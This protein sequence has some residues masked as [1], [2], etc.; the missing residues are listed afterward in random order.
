MENYLDNLD[1]N[2]VKSITVKRKRVEDLEPDVDEPK[3]KVRKVDKR[4]AQWILTW[5]HH[6]L[7]GAIETLLGLAQLKHW[8]IQEEVGEAKGTPHLQG[9]LVFKTN[10]RWSTLNNAC[11]KKCYWEKCRNVHAAKNYCSKEL[12]A[13]GKRWVQWFPEV[14][15]VRDPLGG[16]ELYDWQKEVVEIV[17]GEPDLRKV[18][19]FWSKAGG[20]GK[21][22]LIKHLCIE[23]PKGIV[24]CGGTFKDAEYF[25]AQREKK[26]LKTNVVIFN[27]PRSKVR[28]GKPMISYQ[29]IEEIKDGLFFSPKYESAM[30]LM[31]PPHVLV[32]ANVPP[33]RTQLSED[34]WVIKRLDKPP[35]EPYGLFKWNQEI[36]SENRKLDHM[37]YGNYGQ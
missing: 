1:M 7:P 11:D 9:V 5:N 28:E 22:A 33:D 12:T 35:T 13:T 29:G 20:I 4:S 25:I 36:E 19:W 3:A 2:E 30:V 21:S 23:D 31:N 32:F 8:C 37:R 14:A 6:E 17:S 15:K 26:K 18:Y 34:R 24:M 16:K 27:V 10:V